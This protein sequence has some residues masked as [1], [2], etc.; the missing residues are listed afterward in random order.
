MG[1]SRK[2]YIN[3]IEKIKGERKMWDIKEGGEKVDDKG[4]LEMNLNADKEITVQDVE[5]NK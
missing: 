2:Y 5:Y 1:I 4:H 3:K